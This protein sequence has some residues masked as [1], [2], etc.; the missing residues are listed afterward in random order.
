M[1]RRQSARCPVCQGPALMDSSAPD[2]VRCRISTCVHNHSSVECPRC[3]AADLESVD[4]RKN[5]FYYHC[6]ECQKTWNIP[7]TTA[8]TEED[9]PEE[10]NSEAKN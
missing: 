7:E 6:R 5:A 9:H 2:V 8:K 4:Y 3:G 10:Q 1:E